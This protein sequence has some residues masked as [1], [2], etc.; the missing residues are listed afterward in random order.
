MESTFFQ[1]NQVYLLCGSQLSLAG[2]HLLSSKDRRW[3][4]LIL[5]RCQL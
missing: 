4:R 3:P 2:F 1:L 5:N